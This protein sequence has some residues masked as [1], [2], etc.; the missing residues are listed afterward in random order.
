M[1]LLTKVFVNYIVRLH[2]VYVTNV[3]HCNACF[4]SKFWEVFL[5]AMNTKFLSSTTFHPQ[6]NSQSE[7]IICTLMDMLRLF[8]L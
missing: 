8:V 7:R 2:G 4:T 1:N 5:K 3:S 6:T